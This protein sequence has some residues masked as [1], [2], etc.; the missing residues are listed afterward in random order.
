[1]KRFQ[2]GNELGESTSYGSIKLKIKFPKAAH[3]AGKKPSFL[4]LVQTC[5]VRFAGME[6]LKYVTTLQNYSQLLSQKPFKEV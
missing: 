2:R 5:A 6:P 4:P 3:R 1:M